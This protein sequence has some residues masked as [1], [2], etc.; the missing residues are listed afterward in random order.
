MY[1]TVRSWA[2]QLQSIDINQLAQCKADLLVV[3]STIDGT[4]ALTPA[5]VLKLRRNGDRRVLCYLSIGEA[6]N[7]RP[8]WR[9]AWNDEAKRP[10]WIVQENTDWPG[11]FAV[12][13]WRSDWKT[14]CQRMITIIMKQGFDGIYLDK[15]DVVWDLVELDDYEG[16]AAY[17]QRRMA[18]FIG[19]L[20]KYAKERN[21][22][23]AVYM[24]NAEHLLQYKSLRDCLDGAAK[25]ELVYRDQK[26]NSPQ[27]LQESYDLLNHMRLEGKPV[28]C[29]EY[30]DDFG[31]QLHATDI[32]SKSMGFIPYIANADRE[33]GQLGSIAV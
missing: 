11:N 15:A 13:F 25:E 6:E 2:Y 8:Y 32:A 27:D 3:D 22:N 33:L 24:Q 28:L 10:D 17:L 19:D 29:V 20:A 9:P 4:R 30:L 16:A 23:F 1:T 21:A 18:S 31:Q 5:E 7:Y 26:L 12:E 14:I